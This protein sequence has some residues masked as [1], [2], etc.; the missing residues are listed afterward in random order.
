MTWLF[1]PAWAAL[2]VAMFIIGRR[3][4]RISVW[5]LRHLAEQT[6]SIVIPVTGSLVRHP[7][8]DQAPAPCRTSLRLVREQTPVV[9]L[10]DFETSGDG[11]VA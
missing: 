9:P 8:W 1:L 5:L 11:S 3:W 4:D 7:S 2:A 10:F 6:D